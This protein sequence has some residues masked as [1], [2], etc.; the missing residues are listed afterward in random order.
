MN[1][2]PPS[3]AQD[4]VVAIPP[5][6]R[7]A[8]R[9]LLR[10]AGVLPVV[11]V[12]SVDQAIAIATALASG[13][14]RAIEVT[15]RSPAAMAA[16]GAVK[17][18]LPG[19]AVGAGTVLTADQAA[20]ARDQ[21]ADFLVTPGTPPLL[22]R[23][24]AALDLPVIPGAATATE[25]IALLAMGFDALKLFPATA[26]GGIAMIR[27][28]AGPFPDL[29]LCPTGGINESTAREYLAQPNVLCV[30]G[31][32]MVPADWIMAGRFDEVEASARRARAMVEEFAT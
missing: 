7:A 16:L 21:G 14:L 27:S 22:A 4:P 2:N 5:A 8:A 30:G 31:S 29:A 18:A 10:N 24:L 15:L 25:I 13:G 23:A 20:Q 3:H 32:W 1:R 17:R 6:R 9:A 12:E 28:L 19:T 11:T 26:V